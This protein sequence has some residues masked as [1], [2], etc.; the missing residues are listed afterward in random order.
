MLALGNWATRKKLQ[1]ELSHEQSKTRFAQFWDCLADKPSLSTRQKLRQ[2][3]IRVRFRKVLNRGSHAPLA[4]FPSQGFVMRDRH[5]I[6]Y[7]ND[8]LQTPQ[9]ERVRLQRRGIA[10]CCKSNS[11]EGG[12]RPVSDS[13]LQA[14]IVNRKFYHNTIRQELY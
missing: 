11:A 14:C 12:D 4:V 9:P 10:T 8:R 1:R 3:Q 5:F 6:W 7:L 2:S 13:Y